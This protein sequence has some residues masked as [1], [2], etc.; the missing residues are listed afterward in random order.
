M[1]NVIVLKKLLYNQL[2]YI[3]DVGSIVWVWLLIQKKICF[4]VTNQYRNV[5]ETY[6]IFAQLFA[7]FTILIN[8]D[9]VKINIPKRIVSPLINS[10]EYYVMLKNI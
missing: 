6:F 1:V 2:C 4:S 3:A 7:P 8:H 9:K 10:W 5:R